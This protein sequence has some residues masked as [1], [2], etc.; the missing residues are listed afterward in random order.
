[1]SNKS[2]FRI[3]ILI[4]LLF[5]LIIGC[6]SEEEDGAELKYYSRSDFYDRTVSNYGTHGNN[7]NDLN[8]GETA[9]FNIAIKNQGTLQANSVKVSLSSNDTYVTVV[10]LETGRST[11]AAGQIKDTD[12]KN[13][14]SSY[15][16]N[17]NGGSD[18]KIAV[19]S[20]APNGHQATINVSMADDSD[21]TWTDN[22]RVTV[23]GISADL[24]YHSMSDLYDQAS[25]YYGTQGNNDNILNQSETARFNI[26]VNNQGT[27]QANNVKVSL[28]SD[29]IY[30]TVTNVETSRHT[31]A[32]GQIEDTDGKNS[33]SSYFLD[34]NASN[35]FKFTASSSTPAGHQATINVSM[36]DEFGNTWTDSFTVTVA[37]ISAD[38]KYH[39]M[40]DFYDQTSSYYGTQGNND[41]ALNP[42][43]TV[44]FNI[45]VKNQ[46]TSQ[47]N[48]VGV[49]L[50]SEDAY[51]TVT[52]LETSKYTI[53]GGQIKDTDGYSSSSS[54]FLDRS[55]NND[56]KIAASSS[57]PTGHQATI[58]V[59]IVDEFGNIWTDS[60]TVTVE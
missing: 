23:V 45:A 28:S 40:S 25:P 4:V 60:F 51:I 7:D 36:E 58:N 18:F 16:L 15:F 26:A 41:N 50:S 42:G 14:S 3:E 20:S 9:R 19:S 47:A 52:N 49:S 12:G 43:E 6:K 53:A 22:F 8:Q 33:S 56:F 37:G 13:S 21:N 34:R 46:G 59:S 55:V 30:V 39:S 24:K 31:I 44:K 27:S 32:G 1:M 11:I 48:N 17:R 5:L 38:L 10:T 54:Y 29:D 57:T 35:D 2:I